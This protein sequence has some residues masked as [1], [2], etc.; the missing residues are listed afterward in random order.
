MSRIFTT[1]VFLA[2]WPAAADGQVRELSLQEAIDIAVNRSSRGE[3]IRGDLEVAQQNYEAERINFYIPEISVNGQ[4]PVFNVTESFR[5]FGGLDQK[6]LIRTTDRDFRTF[7]QLTQSLMTGGQLTATGNLWNRRSEYP[8]G[9]S[10]VTEV[11]NQ[12]IFE[13]NFEQPLLKPSESKNKLHNRRDDLEIARLMRVEELA[14]LKT[15]VAEAYFGALQ[16]QLELEITRDRAESARLKSEIDSVKLSDGVVSEEAWLESKSSRLDAELETYD[17][18][19]QLSEKNRELALLLDFEIGQIVNTST[20]QVAEHLSERAREGL[21]AAWEESVPIKKA[22]Y[23]YSKAK[24]QADY[25]ASS[26]GLTGSLEANYSLGRGDVDVDGTVTDNNT[27][28]WGV[29]LNF[30][31]PLWDGGSTGAAIKAARITA[32][33]SQLEYERLRKSARAEIVALLHR[34]DVSFRKLDVMQKQIDLAHDKLEIARF[35]YDDGQISRIDFLDSK[36]FYLEA[37][38]KYL[39]ELKKYLITK[40]EVEGK[41]SG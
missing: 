2:V 7:I 34:L 13:F 11:S 6:E 9:D 25:T 30:T 32:Q 3:I 40:T 4:A 5:F 18:E 20:P 23:E 36:V 17:K 35:R 41:Y 39:E 28:S 27:D 24:R 8:I 38:T 12:G 19:N 22:W 16:S 26:H 1:I 29:S 31:L 21:V 15:E 37:Q 33:K 10:D 14:K